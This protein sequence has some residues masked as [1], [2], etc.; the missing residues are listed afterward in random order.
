M[1]K[2]NKKLK[3]KDFLDDV[4]TIAVDL[5][6]EVIKLIFTVLFEFFKTVGTKRVSGLSSKEQ[7]T[8]KEKI[9]KKVL[10]ALVSSSRGDETI[11]DEDLTNNSQS[12]SKDSLGYD[13]DLDKDFKFSDYTADVPLSII[14]VSE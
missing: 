5:V 14:L 6:E 11:S 13:V 9:E 3:N 7:L 1:Q 8:K 10:K 2:N 4:I 12:R